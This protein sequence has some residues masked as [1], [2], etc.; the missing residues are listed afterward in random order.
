MPIRETMKSILFILLTWTS[1]GFPAGAAHELRGS[2]G[3]KQ[4]GQICCARV[5]LE[6]NQTVTY[7]GH[8]WEAASACVG[9][10][11]MVQKLEA[12]CD[13]SAEKGL[14]DRPS[15]VSPPTSSGRGD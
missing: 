3:A 8:G 13:V 10:G 15:Q 4:Q 14:S 11:T 2:S 9:A 1:V 5:R 6:G 12:H 7:I